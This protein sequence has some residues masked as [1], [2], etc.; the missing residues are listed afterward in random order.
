M[1]AEE[2][3]AVDRELQLMG[4]EID[5]LWKDNESLRGDNRRLLAD[6]KSLGEVLYCARVLDECV[7]AETLADLSRA[8]AACAAP[9]PRA[10]ETAGGLSLIQAQS[11]SMGRKP[12]APKEEP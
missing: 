2:E 5:K 10:C 11:E 9:E 12:P 1:D 4:R 8:V 7:D 3:A 6:N